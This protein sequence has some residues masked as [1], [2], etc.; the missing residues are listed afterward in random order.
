MYINDAE[1]QN[2]F[3]EKTFIVNSRTTKIVRYIL[4]KIELQNGGINIDITTDDNSIEHILPEKPN[5]DWDIDE[6]RLDSLVSRLGNL[7]L[8]ES[9]KNKELGN[10]SYSKKKEIY[11]TSQFVTTKSIP[12][13]YT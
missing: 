11:S 5:D 10:S 6:Y 3:A 4:N 13:K 7:C 1:F 12:E 8:L 9:N 2:S